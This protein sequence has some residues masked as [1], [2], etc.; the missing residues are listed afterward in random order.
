MHDYIPPHIGF[1][2]GLA[3]LLVYVIVLMVQKRKV[4][5]TITENGEV[6]YESRVSP[7]RAAKIIKNHFPEG[8]KYELSAE[9]EENGIMVPAELVPDPDGGYKMIRKATDDA[10]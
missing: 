5:L 4:L 9:I 10:S 2:L 6:V 8:S 1:P 3:L 7:E